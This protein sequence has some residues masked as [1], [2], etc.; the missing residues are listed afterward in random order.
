VTKWIYTDIN[1]SFWN[2]YFD[3]THIHRLNS[4]DNLFHANGIQKTEETILTRNKLE[5]K[6]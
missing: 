2:T 5:F 6:L 4:M 1:I 3:P